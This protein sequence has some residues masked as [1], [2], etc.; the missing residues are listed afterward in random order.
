MRCNVKQRRRV[1]IKRINH[2]PLPSSRAEKPVTVSED[3]SS[4]GRRNGDGHFSQLLRPSQPL[5]QTAVPQ[6]RVFYP[7][8]L[9]PFTPVPIFRSYYPILSFNIPHL[10]IINHLM[11][12]FCI[13]GAGFCAIRVYARTNQPGFKFVNLK[14]IGEKNFQIRSLC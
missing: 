7:I 14:K 1:L 3:L 4:N 8:P 6:I 12:Y 11:F 9:F 2:S 5:L 13:G 10:R